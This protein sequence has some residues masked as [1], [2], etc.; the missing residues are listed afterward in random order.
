M[1]ISVIVVVRNGERFLA[2]ALASIGAQTRKPAEVIVVEG[3]STDQSA[4]IARSFSWVRLIHQT[5]N[6]LAAARNQGVQA[7]VGDLVAFLD[8]DD[9]WAAEKLALQADYLAAQPQ[10]AAVTGQLIRFAQPDCPIPDQY[11]NNWLNQPAPAYTPGGLLVRRELFDSCGSFDPAF[12]IGCDSDWLARVQDVG[13]PLA[14]L[15]Q[16]VLR[17]RIHE[18][19]LSNNL[20]IARRELLALTRRS[21]VRRHLLHDA[22]QDAG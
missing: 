2:E 17:K 3:N 5:G 12:T 15:P 1:P 10:S 20:T 7:A 19:N 6:G 9:L 14:I 22:A 11:Q 4:A 16:V 18:G 13:G 8:A 21:L